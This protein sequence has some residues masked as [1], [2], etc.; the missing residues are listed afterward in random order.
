MLAGNPSAQQSARVVSDNE[1]RPE[2]IDNSVTSAVRGNPTVE[3]AIGGPPSRSPGNVNGGP[4]AALRYLRRA[5]ATAR[6]LAEV[7]R[8]G[9]LDTGE[10]ASPFSVVAEQVNYRLRHYFADDA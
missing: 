5:G 7:V 1:R 6:N 8:F 10:E 3:P 2:L 4:L 9:G